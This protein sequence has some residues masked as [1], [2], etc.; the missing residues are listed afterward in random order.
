VRRLPNTATS[1][2]AVVLMLYAVAELLGY[3]GPIAALMF[4]VALAN[5]RKLGLERLPFVRPGRVASLTAEDREINGE[6]TFLVKAFFFVYLGVSI[7][8]GSAARAWVALVCVALVYLGRHFTVAIATPAGTSAGD[9]AVMA[10]MAP[11]GLAAAVLGAVPL[12][13]GLA[14]GEAIQGFTYLVV[15]FSI[16]AT[17]LLVWAQQFPTVSRAYARLFGPGDAPRGSARP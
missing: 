7:P 11:K 12:R 14:G 10:V 17:A 6:V 1:S 8:L 16:M 2:I 4:G 3:S 15:L 5:S 13:L 9:R